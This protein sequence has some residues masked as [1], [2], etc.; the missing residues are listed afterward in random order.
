MRPT[1]AKATG[2][3][4]LQVANVSASLQLKVEYILVLIGEKSIGHLL[5]TRK[6]IVI[7]YKLYFRLLSP[8]IDI[9]IF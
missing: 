3:R 7:V 5:N 2:A 8:S 9:S 1:A 4:G 6:I